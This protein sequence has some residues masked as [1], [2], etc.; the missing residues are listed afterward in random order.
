MKRS[1]ENRRFKLGDIKK[2]VFVVVFFGFIA[3]PSIQMLTN[4]VDVGEVESFDEKRKMATW[5][6]IETSSMDTLVATYENY[7]KDNFGFRDLFISLNNRWK[8]Q[9]F[10][11]SPSKS[12]IIG[13]DRWYF[14]DAANSVNDHT[15]KVDLTETYLKE[16]KENLLYKKEYIEKQ[17]GKFYLVVLPDKM[18]VYSRYLPSLE[19]GSNPSR[20]DQII[21]YCKGSGVDIVD[22]R[23]EMIKQGKKNLIYQK[24]DSHW[25]FNG[26]FIGYQQIMK[27]LKQDF[28]NLEYYK[29]NQFDITESIVHT[30]DLTTLVGVMNY[31]DNLWFT[32][33]PK[34]NVYKG[35]VQILDK[36]QNYKQSY[37]ATY[38]YLNPELDQPK[39]LV[40]N[41]SYIN[42]V[43]NFFGNHFSESHYFWSHDFDES[44]VDEVQPE[45]FIQLIVERSLENIVKLDKK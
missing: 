39:L 33:T 12:V 16:L 17:G 18:S 7:F 1:A 25:N 29:K 42:Y 45:I 20:L 14:L 22:I 24:T 40:I 19:Y 28:P 21:S 8:V 31:E 2:L 32:Y 36:Y 10:K 13:K 6:E 3:V 23:P 27:R 37:K 30:G 9:Q 26:G 34:P 38:S 11:I 15:G 4:F 43:H 44:V 41:D 35:K 5:H